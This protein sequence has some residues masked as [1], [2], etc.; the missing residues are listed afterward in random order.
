MSEWW[1]YSLT[2]FLL[3]SPRTYYRLFELYNAAI[4]PAQIFALFLGTVIAT[5]LWSGTPRRIRIALALLAAGWCWVGWGFHLTRYATINWAAVYFAAAFA[6]Q[7]VLLLVFVLATRFSPSTQA[8]GRAWIGFGL[9]A[10]GLVVHPVI[11]PLLGRSWPQVEVFAVAPDPT[12]VATLGTILLTSTRFSW[13]LLPIPIAWCGVSG[14]T[15]WAMDAPDAPIMPLAAAL[16]I[17]GAC[18]YPGV[19][20]SSE[21]SASGSA[22]RM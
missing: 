16:A 19:S 7:A 13:A 1:T 18:R 11:G 22:K 3:F 8:G 4:W 15:Q 12:V 2:D 5:L 17:F 14:A 10:F 21:V 9:L 20:T 6:V